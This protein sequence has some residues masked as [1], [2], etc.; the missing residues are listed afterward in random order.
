M[1][2]GSRTSW[3]KER[4]KALL[5]LGKVARKI[6]YAT[7][8]DW[9]SAWDVCP[10]E[11]EIL[12]DYTIEQLRKMYTRVLKA[13]KGLC[14]QEHCQ[15]KTDGKKRYCEVCAKKNAKRALTYWNE[16]GKVKREQAHRL[17]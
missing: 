1:K 14:I 10:K 3:T 8:K 15:S 2:S 12:K 9:Q 6:G 13:S 16:K 7:K 4:E 17:S 11:R 5:K